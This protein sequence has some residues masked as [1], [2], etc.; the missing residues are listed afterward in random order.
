MPILTLTRD[1]SPGLARK[2]TTFPWDKSMT[3]KLNTIQIDALR[4]ERPSGLSSITAEDSSNAS[5]FLKIST[6]LLAS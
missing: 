2:H 1:G 3:Q 6:R 4:H 5:S